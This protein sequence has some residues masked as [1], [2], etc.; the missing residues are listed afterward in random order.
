M[1]PKFEWN[2]KYDNKFKSLAAQGFEV[3]EIANKIGYG[4]T[5]RHVWDRAIK[6]D[7]K[8]RNT[9]THKNRRTSSLLDDYDKKVVAAV[10]AGCKDIS[11]VRSA[12]GF[13]SYRIIE[14]NKRLKLK[15]KTDKFKN[16]CANMLATSFGRGY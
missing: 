16:Q 12:T 4:C 11:S 7:V 2:D 15:I 8:L 14:I 1:K 10:Q 13:N 5:S 9:R 3:Y 6:L